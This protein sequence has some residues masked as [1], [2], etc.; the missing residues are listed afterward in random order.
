MRSTQLGNRIIFGS[1]VFGMG[2]GM[3]LLAFRDLKTALL[4]GVVT[5]PASYT[6]IIMLDRRRN[7]QQK[8]L[9]DSL[10]NRLEDLKQEVSNLELHEN[11]LNYSVGVSMTLYREVEVSVEALQTERNNLLN[12]ISELHQQRGQLHQEFYQ[13]RAKLQQELL[14][15][16]K[17]KQ[18]IEEDYTK[19]NQKLIPLKKHQNQLGKLLLEQNHQIQ[20]VK[21]CLSLLNEEYAKIEGNLLEKHQQQEKLRQDVENL[22]SQKRNLLEEIDNLKNSSYQ[23]EVRKPSLDLFAI[24]IKESSDKGASIE[25]SERSSQLEDCAEQWDELIDSFLES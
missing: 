7:R 12:R 23:L 24:E 11:Q 25:P 8:L 16:S 21:T 6:G 17:K 15:I 9:Q 22:R 20:E 19:L 4:A 10:E 13:Q 3:A 2:L 14:S 1:V 5:V 18:Q